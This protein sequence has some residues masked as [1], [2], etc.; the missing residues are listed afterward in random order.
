MIFK[1]FKK[2]NSG[3]YNLDTVQENVATVFDTLVKNPIFNGVLLEDLDLINGDTHINHKLSRKLQG[4]I[5]VRVDTPCD[6]YD[7]QSTN[8]IQDRTLILN[9]DAACTV[10]LYVF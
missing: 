8:S 4:W 2:I 6:I 7:K 5:V 9:S 3:D 1:R 10:N